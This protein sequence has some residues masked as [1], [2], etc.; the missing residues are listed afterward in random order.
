M[1]TLF[2][3]SRGD[4]EQRAVSFQ[5]VFGK[6]QDVLGA[7]TVDRALT[8]I[9]VFAATRLIADSIAS[10]PVQSFRRTDSARERITDPQ[11][12]QQPTQFGSRYDW[13]F[14]ALT[15]W[16]FR[17]NI[18][19]L[20]TKTDLRGFPTQVEWLNPDEVTVADDRAVRNPAF[21]W[22][23]QE[24]P[25]SSRTGFIHIPGFTLPGRVLGISPIKAYALTLDT[26]LFA[27]FFG[28]DFFSGGGHPHALLKNPKPVNRDGATRVKQRFLASIRGREPAVMGD[29]WE[30]EQIQVS[31]EESQFLT[32]IKA[33]A[34]DIAAIYGIISPELIGGE[35]A[36]SSITYATV[37]GR[38]IDF[39]QFT[40]RPYLTKLEWA[41][42]TLLPERQFVKFNVD[43]LVRAD[44]STRMRAHTEALVAGWRSVNEVRALEDL[45][46]I[47]NG[48][49]YLWPPRRQQLTKPEIELGADD[50]SEAA[51]DGVPVGENPDLLLDAKPSLNGDGGLVADAVEG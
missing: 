39:V 44:L 28:R 20:V 40:L 26:G 13:V 17:G 46:P 33:S 12:I 47:P 24:L 1:S 15:S 21:K 43:A 5:D 11:L 51:P 27:R 7:S 18:F 41:F 10:L 31:P 8:L 2:R 30:Y 25:R 9:P 38:H 37:E 23:G 49:N 3:P 16:L 34:N 14:R 50:A 32:T 22:N 42:S 6:G 29:G 36:G 45:A 35:A 4:V 19:G 48:D